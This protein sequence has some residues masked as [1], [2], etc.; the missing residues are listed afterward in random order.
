MFKTRLLSGIVL[1]IVL[2]VTVGYGNELLFAFTGAVSL[3]GL[4]E[5]Y[6]VVGVQ[7]RALG[8]AGYLAAVVYYGLLWTGN[9]EYMTMFSLMFLVG[10]MAVYVFTFPKFRAEQ[11][12]T[13]FFGFFY[14]AVMLFYVY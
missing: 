13:V 12:M 4:K 11:V 2:I 1:V 5:L 3:V 10:V 6:S 9:M 14:V 7:K 8:M